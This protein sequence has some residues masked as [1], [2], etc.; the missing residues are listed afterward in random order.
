MHSAPSVS[1]PVG[2]SAFAGALSA[3]LWL[4]GAGAIL[5]WALKSG[6][7]TG[8]LVAASLVC[9]A[10]GL[11]SGRL[12]WRTRAGV[13]SWDGEGWSCSTAALGGPA[14]AIVV[15]DLQGRMLVRLAAA[16]SC[17]VWLE[18]HQSPE[19]WDDVRRAAHSRAAADRLLPAEPHP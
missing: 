12:W 19:R 9:A 15:L 10:A 8:R 4:L 7:A 6:P 3:L 11:A 1:Y 2:R 17:W 13:V 14:R 16:R 5:A 18:R